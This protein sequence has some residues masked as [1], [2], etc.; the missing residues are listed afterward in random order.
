[1][2]KQA[3]HNTANKSIC[4]QKQKLSNAWTTSLL[5]HNSMFFYFAESVLETFD[6]KIICIKLNWYVVMCY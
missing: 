2:M 5:H 3:F 4:T 1:M 6:G